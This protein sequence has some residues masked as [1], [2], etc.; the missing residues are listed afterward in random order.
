[1]SVTVIIIQ[2]Y[3]LKLYI[4]L[5]AR[6][7]LSLIRRW[8]TIIA[9]ITVTLVSLVSLVYQCFEGYTNTHLITLLFCLL[10]WLPNLLLVCSIRN[11]LKI[12]FDNTRILWQF[13]M[14]GVMIQMLLSF[15]LVACL[16]IMFAYNFQD[17][18]L[19]FWA[20]LLIGF[21]D[22]VTFMLCL[23]MALREV[24]A[25]YKTVTIE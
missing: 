19:G 1:M 23:S 4:V 15:Y 2:D 12:S 10:L 11:M 8:Y 7:E 25:I 16:L 21:C 13:T 3:M 22:F 24:A 17:V 6:H 5:T 20:V 9:L 18:D 14:Q